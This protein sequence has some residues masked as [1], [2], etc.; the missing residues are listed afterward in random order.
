MLKLLSG[1]NAGCEIEPR[2]L[3]DLFVQ[4][5]L[6]S[7]V[8]PKKNAVQAWP[9]RGYKIHRL[10]S[11]DGT[12]KFHIVFDDGQG[13]RTTYS[14]IPAN[15]DPAIAEQFKAL[16]KAVDFES[17]GAASAAAKRAVEHAMAQQDK[18]GVKL[19]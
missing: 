19:Y 12:T 15:C 6:V 13:G 16:T 4:L 8:G 11:N 9:S 17:Q 2:D 10:V 18:P 3:V 1:P 14:G 7:I 5:G